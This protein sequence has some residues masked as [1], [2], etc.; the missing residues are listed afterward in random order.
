MTTNNERGIAIIGI[1]CRYP[2]GIK[3]PEDLWN[4]VMRGEDAIT[5]TP[6]D[7][8]SL[9][10]YFSS[11]RAKKGKAVTRWGGYIDG[12]DQ[13][14]PHFFGISPREAE[15]MDPQQRLLLEVS[16][17]AFEDAGI[18]PSR[19]AGKNAGVFVGGFTLDYKIMQFGAGGMDHIGAHTAVGSMMTM[20]SNR[21]SYT[22]DLRGPS[23]SVDTACSSSL[24]A[25][26]LA[27]SAIENGECDLALAG[28]VLLSFTPQYTI[29]ESQGGFLSP[30]G[31]S[32][33]YDSRANGYV[34]GEGVGIVLLKPL[35]AAL[36]DGDPIYAVI[37]GTAV[38]QDGAT[39][40]ITVPS[41]E[42]Q[43]NLIR[44]ACRR[45]GVNPPE[46]QYVEAHGTGTPVG[47]PIEANA[48]GEVFGADRQTPC[49]VGSIKTNI[50][51]TESAAGVAGL[52]K[53]S[54]AMT[55]GKI[56]PHLH[57]LEAN[58]NI[59]FAALKLRVPT[60]VED[61]P[62][63]A[64]PK[65]AGVNSFGF[66]G[67][68]A[69]AV[70]IEAPAAEPLAAASGSAIPGAVAARPMLFPISA[71]SEESLK[72][73][74]E[75]YLD[76]LEYRDE[77]DLYALG[78][79]MANKRE[80][81]HIRLAVA[82][83][84][85][86]DLRTKLAL[87]VAG[88]ADPSVVSGRMLADASSRLAFVFSGMGPQWWGMARRLM[89]D[90]AFFAAR[91]RECS[92]EFEK[93]AGWSLWD[94]MN[95]DEAESEMDRTR[96]SQ[97]ANFAVQYALFETLA[98]DGIRPAAIVGH[99]TGEVAAF[100]AAG[101]YSLLDAVKVIYHR[102]A[103][104]DTLSGTGKMLA[105]GMGEVAALD[106][107]AKYPGRVSIAAVNSDSAVTLAGEADALEEIARDLE[108]RSVFAKFLKVDIPFHSPVME[109]IKEPLLA[110][111][112]GLAA[113][114]ATVPLYSTGYGRKVEGPE[115]D[116]HYWWINVRHSV[117]FSAALERMFA[118]D[119]AVFLEIGP[120]PVLSGSISEA[121]AARGASVKALH[122]LSRKQ[123]DFVSYYGALAGLH[124][125]GVDPDWRSF[126]P[127]PAPFIKLPRYRWN[128]ERYW[129]ESEEGRRKRLGE[130]EH[131]LLG[132][133][134]NVNEPI[135][136]VE[137]NPETQSYLNDH[138]IKG[139]VLCPAAFYAEAAFE[140]VWAYAG[141]GVYS[142]RDLDISKALFLGG[143]AVHRLQVSLN[144]D[145]FGFRITDHPPVD[146]PTE[147]AVLSFGRVTQT[148]GSWI[149]P[150][151]DLAKL[152]GRCGRSMPGSEAY[153]RLDALGFQ[154]GPHFR[155]ITELCLGDRE[156]LASI[157]VHPEVR[158][159]APSY[160]IHPSLL[161]ICFHTLLTVPFGAEDAS[162][163]GGDIKL[164]VSVDS[165]TVYRR[166]DRPFPLEGLHVHAVSVREDDRLGVGDIFLLDG[167]GRTL[168]EIRGFTVQA[169]DSVRSPVALKTLDSWLYGLEWI[170]A[171]TAAPTAP[172][173]P[174]PDTPPVAVEGGTEAAAVGAEASATDGAATNAAAAAKTD[175]VAGG[176]DRV[177]LVFADDHGFGDSL[178]AALNERGLRTVVVRHGVGFTDED[179]A[180]A[181]AA[182]GEAGPD[183]VCH[184][185]SFDAPEG[186]DLDEAAL[187]AGSL[188]SGYGVVRIVRA[189][190][191]A[192]STAKTWFF[193]RGAQRVVEADRVLNLAQAGLWGLGRVIGNQEFAGWWGGL[194]DVDAIAGDTL[195]A[196]LD[197]VLVNADRE[198]QIAYRGGR[199]YIQRLNRLRGLNA[200]LPTRLDPSAAYLVTGAFGSLGMLTV[201]WMASRG[202][203]RLILTARGA[204]PER[205]RWKAVG[206]EDRARPRIEFL[207]ELEA[208]GVV[209]H[210]WDLDLVDGEKLEAF[211]AAYWNDQYPP[212][213]GVINIAGTVKDRLM[214][215]MDEATFDEVWAPKVLG[216]RN[217]HQAF[218]DDPL[219]FFVIY[220]SI[221]AVVASAGQANYA[222][223]NAFL[224]ALALQRRLDGR[225][226]LAI[227]WGPWAIGMIKELK[228]E[229]LY[230]RKGIDIIEPA[231]G[232][233]VL[234][235]LIAQDTAH[236]AVVGADWATVIASGPRSYTA[237]IDHL[238]VREEGQG[239]ALSDAEVKDRFL[240]S[241]READ[242]NARKQLVF[243]TFAAIVARVMRVKTASLERGTVL[244]G[245]GLDSMMAVEL[246]NRTELATGFAVS[247]VDLLGQADLGQLADKIRAGVAEILEP[248]SVEELIERTDSSEME[249]LL[250]KLEGMSEEEALALLGN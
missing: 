38:N 210:V 222:C 35:E 105:V 92:D 132:A 52:I 198:D 136:P 172:T 165:I 1:G 20:L 243:E 183:L 190:A 140:A 209:V 212:I 217:L 66:G 11:S 236:A 247:V 169:M 87:F 77:Q 93:L 242:E 195:R 57:F 28:G 170:A 99:S 137:V 67:T 49:V 2:G 85:L 194:I 219:D 53:A 214:T 40:G 178:A 74:A 103:L 144:R 120:H 152:R 159:W 22:F 231:H 185:W 48:L 25:V 208:A 122:T 64:G 107:C 104:Q 229:E 153:T 82:A 135:W 130:R 211:K 70:L 187:R 79:N 100:Y 13:F 128:N 123:D 156:V 115:L 68:N 44:E 110:G 129:I 149:G 171:P 206:A 127:D 180:G 160:V 21:I 232:M 162:S 45:A 19:L 32:K 76:F 108:S 31:R 157:D 131:T 181:I 173:D 141:A 151:F 59:D 226:A 23:L 117:H 230:K 218:K 168:V 109:R 147:A 126:Y 3:S 36:A 241:F 91:V 188:L 94:A 81:H 43:K 7:R 63:H 207:R 158:E 216:C 16:W 86:E 58:P 125:C 121:A 213:K 154:Y 12:I 9:D 106:E 30:D 228:L 249:E 203:R 184:L 223:A 33:A 177:A 26:H 238:A 234:E 150:R 182:C 202:A 245:I 95:K 54:L 174:A 88:E 164:P 119:L 61:W 139:S 24:V 4:L 90:D 233:Q 227:G 175:A 215:E 142:I 65:L 27:C 98:R 89:T 96:V 163:A 235:R 60:A 84:S 124:A 116:A 155:G 166:D 237:Y 10:S 113:R 220:S 111:L 69:H 114:K 239:P 112:A 138:V 248:T 146:A 221:A 71:R 199:R 101:V 134:I 148:Q 62:P 97:P 201:R 244:T 29:A 5:E 225:P 51:H 18:V 167:E 46:I 80:H 118:D 72:L 204:L 224:D 42:A 56:P 161:D 41:G 191:V 179:L 8:W 196:V 6:K 189:L 197:D 50:G 176:A 78:W 133:R 15:C 193:T 240:R 14:D 37:A 192:G 250:A 246:K 55:H 17:E 186:A 145:T 39:Q 83:D 34:R 75:A 102:S 200:P 47:D 73:N 143:D 205:S